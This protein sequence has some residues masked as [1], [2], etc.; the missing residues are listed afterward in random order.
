VLLSGQHDDP[1]LALHPVVAL[2]LLVGHDESAPVLGVEEARGD[3]SPPHEHRVVARR[4]AR[5][6]QPRA[7]RRPGERQQSWKRIPHALA[8]R[9][10]QD[11]VGDRLVQNQAVTVQLVEAGAIA[12]QGPALAGGAAPGV[13][14]IDLQVHDRVRREGLAHPLGGKRAAAERDHPRVAPSQ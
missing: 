3:Q 6:H 7:G 1:L 13:I 14:R 8:A 2:H 9:R 5:P 12:C 10:R 11:G 4:G